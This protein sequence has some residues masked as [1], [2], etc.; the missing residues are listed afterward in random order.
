MAI[1]K[2]LI[3]Q[4]LTD[5]KKPEDIIGENGLLKELTKAILER[6]L[7]AEMTDHLGY[8]KHDPA[9]HH[10]GNTRNGKSP[11]TLKGDF[12]ELE[13]E[14]P[15]DRQATFD[16]K[17]V[18]KGQTRWT[19]F[20]D[21]IISMYARGMTTREIQGHLEEM[22]Q[23]EVS[24]T[25]ISNV[26]DAVLEEVKLWQNRPLEELYP[27]VYLDALMVKVRDEGHVQNKAIYVVLGVNLE[28]QKEVLGLWV[29]Q[30]EGAKFWLQVLTELQNRGVKDIFIACVDGLKGFPEAI[31]AVYPRTEVQLCI[32]HLVR[33]SLNYVPWKVR[34]QVAA[35]LQ[36]IYRAATAAEAE[37]H[38][39][40]LEGKWKA[41]PS[42]SQV[43]R[44]NWAR[45]TPFFNY[46]PDIRRAIY[47]TNSVESLNRS[48]RKIIKTR[49][50]FPNQEAALKLLF[51]ALAA[52]SEEM[53]HADPSLAGST[54][55]LHD[56]VAGT[57]AGPGESCAM[58]AQPP[59][60]WLGRGRECPFPRTPS[61]KTIPGRLHKSLDTPRSDHLSSCPW[62][63]PEPNGSGDRPRHQ[64]GNIHSG[65]KRVS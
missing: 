6:A 47:T 45:I 31:E 64:R 34:K 19:G 38:L 63:L 57:D 11:K 55:P 5:Y 1:D 51:L 24:P 30:N 56:S 25:L 22:Y 21:K 35:D 8:E 16:P 42:V 53:D 48:L 37:Q 26:T 36:S 18:A 13:L 62:P 2:K 23:I 52:G 49:G 10:R 15:R 61:P 59:S 32:V 54:Q 29:A 17:I 65:P 28:G 4:L 43:W 33:A 41:Y 9:G 46:P 3:D 50:G 44:R 40:E 14:T 7:A 27:I 20:D 12:G 58:N 60:T 39:A